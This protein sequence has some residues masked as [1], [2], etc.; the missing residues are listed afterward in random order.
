MRR[1]ISFVLLISIL[2]LP[3]ISAAV[4]E[5]DLPPES[6]PRSETDFLDERVET[7]VFSG[8]INSKEITVVADVMGAVFNLCKEKTDEY[9]SEEQGVLVVG[10]YE[11]GKVINLIKKLD[12]AS[13]NQ[14]FVH[15]YLSK[16]PY[17]AGAKRIVDI[18]LSH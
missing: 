11:S 5:S 4:E 17:Y 3:A 1:L 18:K 2:L 7:V 10:G 13:D 14:V 15:I 12:N 16:E 9:C 6:A 8:Y